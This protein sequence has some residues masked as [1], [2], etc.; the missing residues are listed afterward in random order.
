MFINDK[1]YN[2]SFN[3]FLKNTDE[4]EI[5]KNFINKTVFLDKNSK[6]LDIGGGNGALIKDL[7]DKVGITFIVEPNKL[8]AAQIV[9]EKNIKIINK[10]WEDAQLNDCF[11]FILAAYVVTYFPKELLSDLIAKMYNHLLPGGKIM[12]LSVDAKKGSW[13]EI[14]TY[15]YDLMGMK[16]KS[17]DETL[18]EII[19]K[20]RYL[21]KTFRTHVYADSAIQMLKILEFDFHRHPA[22]FMKYGK[23]LTSFLDKRI[24]RDGRIVLDMVHNAY[25]IYKN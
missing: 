25:I 8:L 21:K 14:H 19:K 24:N 11:D 17:S 23:E 10:K 20:Y 9:K 6:L 13:R 2:E 4:K 22:Q 18:E 16:H 12:I 15:F 1:I 3:L 5:I 7:C